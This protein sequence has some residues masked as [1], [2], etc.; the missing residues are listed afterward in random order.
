MQATF[1]LE[2]N[3]DAYP[4]RLKGLPNMPDVLYGIGNIDVN[5]GHFVSIVGTRR[6]TDRGREM[7]RQLVRDLASLVPDVTIV[8]GLAYGIDIAAH[9]AAIEFDLPTIIV[10][11]HGIDRIYPPLHRPVAV[12]ALERGGIL[13]EYPVGTEPDAWRFIE[14]NRIIA[15]LSD[16]TIVVESRMRGGSLSTARQAL[17]YQRSVFAYPGRPQDENSAGCNALIRDGKA[18]LICSAQDV[19]Q[20]MNWTEPTQ[21]TIH[22][23]T[24]PAAE[25]LTPLQK[26]L[27]DLLRAHEEG[28]HINELVTMTGIAYSELAA[29]LTMMELDDLVHSAP[30]N[31]FRAAL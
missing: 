7:T 3:S 30:G 19:V 22:F 17:L 29:E 24:T 20:M 14:R 23:D 11:A 15:A 6:A 25:S 31:I 9:K 4:H 27:L 12:Q 13:T 2:K 10:P 21:Q 16:C 26:Q 18:R 1:V 8:S 28:L 5:R